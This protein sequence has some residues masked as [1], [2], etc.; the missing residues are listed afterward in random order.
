MLKS[1][2][3]KS[4]ALTD[5]LTEFSPKKPA[6]FAGTC[7]TYKSVQN[8]MAVTAR[9]PLNETL[10]ILVSKMVCFYLTVYADFILY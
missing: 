4:L 9:G 1:K 3:G 10:Q 8:G 7:F 5:A 6:D 2:S